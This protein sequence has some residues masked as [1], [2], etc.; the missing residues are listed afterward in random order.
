[1]IYCRC[2]K[3]IKRK[4]LILNLN[5]NK[6]IKFNS[7]IARPKNSKKSKKLKIDDDQPFF[8]FIYSI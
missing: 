1:M 8:F 7:F 5:K 6:K 4:L 3:N 2:L